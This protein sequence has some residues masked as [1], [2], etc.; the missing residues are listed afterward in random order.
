ML[1]LRQKNYLWC[2][3]YLRLYPHRI[4]LIHPLEIPNMDIGY[5]SHALCNSYLYQISFEGNRLRDI[6]VQELDHY[7][8]HKDRTL[9]EHL[10]HG[11]CYIHRNDLIQMYLQPVGGI[12]L[13]HT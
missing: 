9:V 13:V 4:R 7:L 5:S 2:A 10:T 1:L 6:A 12:N 3:T 11:G 8:F